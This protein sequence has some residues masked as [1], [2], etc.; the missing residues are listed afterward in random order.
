[1][2]IARKDYTVVRNN[3]YTKN[4]FSLRERHNER[5]NEEYANPDI[6]QERSCLNIHFKQC[7]GTYTQAFDKLVEN[8][9]IST[10]GLKS[11]AKV[12]CEFVFDVNTA[13]FEERGGY[14]FAKAFFEEAYRLAV[15]E[16]GGEAYILSAVMHADERNKGLSETLGH[17]VY[18][19]HL[20]VVY[21]PVVEKQIL[22]SK[23][24]KDPA[25]RGTVRE[26]VMQVSRSKK[27]AYPEAVNGKGEPILNKNGKPVRIPSYSL[28]QD[29]FYEHMRLAGFEG[30][31]R[32]ELGSTAK[33]LTTLEYKVQ[34]ETE[35][36]E[37]IQAQVQK[38]EEKLSNLTE[39]TKVSAKANRELHELDH[40]GRR[41][42][43]GK[44]ELPEQDFHDLLSLAR[45]GLRSRG[46]IAELNIR[47]RSFA[48]EIGDLRVAL[49]KLREATKDY[50]KAVKLA[51]Q[52]IKEVFD[53]I[54]S[55]EREERERRAAMRK[56][57]RK[58]DVHSR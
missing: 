50:F 42:L 56:N 51:P 35:K 5:K 58:R 8:G 40:M 49:S 9:I 1:M 10:R 47:L 36:L 34:K 20:H 7:E 12:F 52:R 3:S 26:T 54:F 18:H 19:Y 14:E 48:A 43:L 31:Q 32:G 24:Y 28:L 16:A 4:N 22:W 21:I 44:I 30:F 11:D 38:K 15:Q 39:M 53:E 37:R 2:P 33:N 29:R 17:D 55:R 25:L 23:R 41:T 46:I 45:E 13:Y 27:W 6:L 57:I